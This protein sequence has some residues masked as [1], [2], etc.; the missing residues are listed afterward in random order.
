MD[1]DQTVNHIK[2]TRIPQKKTTTKWW[3]VFFNGP[4]V[5][6]SASHQLWLWWEVLRQPGWPAFRPRPSPCFC[7]AL[8]GSWVKPGR[9]R[10]RQFMMISTD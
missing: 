1:M 4:K 9:I 10:R 8:P 5:K 2:L 7:S 3:K 6:S